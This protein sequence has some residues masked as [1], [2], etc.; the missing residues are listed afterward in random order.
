MAAIT[1]EDFAN[2]GFFHGPSID[3]EHAPSPDLSQSCSIRACEVVEYKTLKAHRPP[4][5]NME[6]ED[7]NA[8]TIELFSSNS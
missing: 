6:T 7:A 1:S 5:A 3:G 4:S 8:P 2:N